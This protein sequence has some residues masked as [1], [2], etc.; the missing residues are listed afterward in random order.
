MV[1][2]G[3]IPELGILWRK[4]KASR[5]R[6]GAPRGEHPQ[7]DTTSVVVQP[8]ET[9]AVISKSGMPVGAVLQA[10]GKSGFHNPV[11]HDGSVRCRGWLVQSD[12]GT[13]PERGAGRRS[14]PSA[15]LRHCLTKAGFGRGK[16]DSSATQLRAASAACTPKR[17][18]K[19][20]EGAAAARQ[21]WA[22]RRASGTT[23]VIE[24][25][26]R[27]G[28]RGL[29]RCR[30]TSLH[31][32]SVRRKRASRHLETIT[33]ART[34]ALRCRAPPRERHASGRA[35]DG[36]P[37]CRAHPLRRTGK[38]RVDHRSTDIEAKAVFERIEARMPVEQSQGST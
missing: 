6:E 32:T 28:A 11:V 31:R 4:P 38:A 19:V 14:V 3:S 26:V 2:P 27:F 33:R 36:S 7:A 5:R 17:N 23:P 15:R 16:A 37:R 10:Q 30:R 8:P 29:V 22:S 18:R 34:L 13:N 24:V 1:P 12:T 35:H 9:P 21:T 25:P 20:P